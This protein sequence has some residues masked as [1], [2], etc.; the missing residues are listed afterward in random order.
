M[1]L[2]ALVRLFAVYVVVL[3]VA[4]IGVHAAVALPRSTA[5]SQTIASVWEKG[6]LLSRAVLRSDSDHDPALETLARDRGLPIVR[7]TILGEGPILASPGLAL[8]LSLVAGRDG[9]KA[10]LATKTAYVTPDDLLAWQGYDRGTSI[11]ELGLTMGADDP[12]IVSLLAEQLHTSVEDVRRH[13]TVRRFRVAR[14]SDAAEPPH[15]HATADT[16]T[17]E[18]VRTAAIEAA[19]YLARGIRIDGRFRFFVDAAKNGWNAGNFEKKFEGS[20]NEVVNFLGI[21]KEEDRAE[22]DLVHS[23]PKVRIV[24]HSSFLSQM[25]T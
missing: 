23:G 7:E 8:S 25:L 21:K 5:S 14:R 9:V 3:V 13:A 18:T 19:R 11:G 4:S 15:A 6:K 10:T 24:L 12:L 1:S 20:K 2:R 16:L 22:K 17:R